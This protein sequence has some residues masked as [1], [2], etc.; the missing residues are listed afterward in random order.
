MKSVV[1]QTWMCGCG[2]WNAGWLEQCGNCDKDKP[3]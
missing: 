2:A 3:K 1:D